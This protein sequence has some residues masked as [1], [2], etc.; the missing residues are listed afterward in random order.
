MY[1]YIYI[2][3]SRKRIC[4]GYLVNGVRHGAQQVRNGFKR[5]LNEWKKESEK[6]GDLEKR[7]RITQRC[8][9]WEE[10]QEFMTGFMRTQK[11]VSSFKGLTKTLWCYNSKSHSR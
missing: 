6:N 5:T 11:E 2:A 7:D 10:R 1:T 4:R 8:G 9:R 3:R